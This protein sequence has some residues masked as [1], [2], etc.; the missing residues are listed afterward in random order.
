MVIV[1]NL[2]L[3]L[4]SATGNNQN[5]SG[6]KRKGKLVCFILPILRFGSVTGSTG[7]AS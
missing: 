2:A 1:I 6:M 7:K 3:A 5:F 4:T